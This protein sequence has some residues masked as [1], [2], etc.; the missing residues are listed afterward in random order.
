MVWKANDS[1]HVKCEKC[2][3]T[4]RKGER[5]RRTK[6]FMCGILNISLSRFCKKC[7]PVKESQDQ[8]I[9]G[10]MSKTI[11]Y[12]CPDATSVEGRDL[13]QYI[14]HNEIIVQFMTS[15]PENIG[16][17]A[18]NSKQFS[19]SKH[20]DGYRVWAVFERGKVLDNINNIGSKN[21]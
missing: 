13:V 20:T 19:V 21:E 6:C 18:R 16:H 7:E 14:T 10:F 12:Y 2:G 1:E 17:L 15:K 3:N 9:V 5:T 8:E 11:R 4:A